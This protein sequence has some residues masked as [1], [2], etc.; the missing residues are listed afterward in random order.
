M[1]CKIETILGWW[2]K[3]H[4]SWRPRQGN[5]MPKNKP[6]QWWAGWRSY[7]NGNQRRMP[8]SKVFKLRPSSLSMKLQRKLH[9]T[10]DLTPQD[11][12]G[13][14]TLLIS[15]IKVRQCL[16]SWISQYQAQMTSS[17]PNRGHY[18]VYNNPSKTSGN[19][20]Y[21]IYILSLWVLV[22]I[23]KQMR[24]LSHEVGKHTKRQ[25]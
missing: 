11:E 23:W 12:C 19:L 15:I 18:L 10:W 8:M 21:N 9:D 1:T 6:W 5:M 24:K 17:A 7:R 3:L 20:L 22:A 16:S 4:G 13:V 25:I 2:D 14:W